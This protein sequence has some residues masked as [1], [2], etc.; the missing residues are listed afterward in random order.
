MG[1]LRCTVVQASLS[2]WLFARGTVSQCWY[3]AAGWG[4]AGGVPILRGAY[5]RVRGAMSGSLSAIACE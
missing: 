3:P 2:R 4:V 5:Q 1:F